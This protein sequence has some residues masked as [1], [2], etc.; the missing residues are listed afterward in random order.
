MMISG[1]WH[2]GALKVKEQILKSGQVSPER[3]FLV[4]PKSIEPEKQEKVRSS[5]VDFRLK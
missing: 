5:R 2:P 4:E 3:V 1:S